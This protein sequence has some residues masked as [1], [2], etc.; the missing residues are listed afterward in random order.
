MAV[1]LN[2]NQTIEK[3]VAEVKRL[4]TLEQKEILAYIKAKQYKKGPRISFINPEKGVKP[5]TMSQIDK[6]K[7]ESRKHAG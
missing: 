3:I 1:T 2:Y 4:T 5:L 6:I 7:H